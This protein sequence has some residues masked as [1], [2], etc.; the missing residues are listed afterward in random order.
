MAAD[1]GKQWGGEDSN[2][3]PTDYESA[4]EQAVYQQER[5][6]EAERPGL[7]VSMLFRPFSPVSILKGTRWGTS[8]G[9]R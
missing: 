1:Q 5:A 6:E 2:L 8:Q 9:L 4:K 3:Q 7:T